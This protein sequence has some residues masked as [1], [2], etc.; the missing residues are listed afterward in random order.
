[1]TTPNSQP[2]AFVEEMQKFSHMDEAE[3]AILAS[4][5]PFLTETADAMAEAFYENLLSYESTAK[6]FVEH[7][8][9]IE[10]LKNHLK[11]WYIGLSNGSYGEQYAQD[12]YRIGYRH[13]EINLDLQYM[14]AAMSFCRHFAIPRLQV[15]LGDGPE[16][17][18][19]ALALDKVMDLDLNL[20]LKTYVERNKEVLEE[21]NAQTLKKFLHVTGMSYELYQS[22][23]RASDFDAD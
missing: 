18:K 8:E 10:S 13:V 1:M 3:K 16:A 7:P 17:N 22:L 14:V 23:L 15:K 9:R 20:M 6:H 21:L 19:A 2:Q 5:K 11:A 12:R 4:L